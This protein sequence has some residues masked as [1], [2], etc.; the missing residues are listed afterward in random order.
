MCI[1]DIIIVVVVVVV[2][3]IIIIIIKSSFTTACHNFQSCL[4]R[5]IFV[6]GE[7]SVPKELNLSARGH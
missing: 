2:I 6:V 7:I 3:T 5:L 4:L 1:N